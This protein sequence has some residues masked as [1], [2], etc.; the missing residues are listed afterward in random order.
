MSKEIVL[1]VREKQILKE[2]NPLPLPKPGP[3]FKIEME[4]YNKVENTLPSYE[5]QN[6]ICDSGMIVQ[7][8]VL[9]FHNPGK[10]FNARILEGNKVQIF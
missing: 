1:I 2:A 9:S 7:G 5:V 4:E 6:M 8:S 10:K 3:N